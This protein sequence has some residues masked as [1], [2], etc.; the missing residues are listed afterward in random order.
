[1]KFGVA[2]YGMN[3]WD[4][5][6]YDLQT[7]LED[8]KTIGYDGIERLTAAS[9]SDAMNLAEKFHRMGMD[10]STVQGP[11]TSNGISW[12]CALG[13]E[14]VWLQPGSVIRGIDMDLFCRRA[15]RMV[16]VANKMN[17]EA[18][19]HNHLGNVVEKQDELDYFMAKVPGAKLILD[20]GHLF[21]AGGNCVEAIEKY[22]DR[23]IAMHFKDVEVVN[24]DAKEWYDRLCFR[25]LDCGNQNFDWRACVRALKKVGYDR[26]C[27]VE[28]DS[29]KDDSIAELTSSL[30]LLK[31]AFAEE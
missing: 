12:T 24:P 29:H 26:W 23:I 18:A 6:L 2:D 1:M 9:P 28:Q 13:K 20:V 3:V 27:F 5:D 25:G 8:L 7:R 31:K 14:Y 11:K 16:E 22:A 21:A 17:V 4:G 30:N 15:A 19:L 10:F